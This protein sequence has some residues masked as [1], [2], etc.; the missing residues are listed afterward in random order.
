MPH[1]EQILAQ[2]APALRASGIPTGRLREL[3]PPRAN[4]ADDTQ[5]LLVETPEGLPS[6]VLLYA[7]AA[8]PEIVQRGVERGREAAHRLGLRAGSAVLPALICGHHE[9]RSYA[10]FPWQRSVADGRWRW[11]LQRGWVVPRV[12]R[13][14]TASI[15]ATAEPVEDSRYEEQVAAPLRR[16][17]EDGGL[18]AALRDDA[19]T[20]L[21]R[22]E[23]GAWRPRS[24]VVH[25]DL[26]KGNILLPAGRSSRRLTAYSIYLI[27]WAAADLSGAPF[28]DLARVGRSLGIPGAWAGWV[29]RRHC[30]LLAYD[31]VDAISSLLV[32]IGRLGARREH[33][34]VEHFLRAAHG[35]HA[36]LRQASRC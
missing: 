5:K 35:T 32:A 13:W 4:I 7:P 18:A 3:T 33:M 15:R 26:W 8:A 30:R 16:V 19:R 11:R 25:N 10:V 14:L 1:V 22:L 31:P 9:G 28:W 21:G 36:W 24:V 17:M 27:D 6:A 23:S 29:T 34:P 12:L 2:I 20:A